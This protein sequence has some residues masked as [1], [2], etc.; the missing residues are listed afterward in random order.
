MTSF[1][2][3]FSFIFTLQIRNA[4]A[5]VS[6][7][8]VSRD[9]CANETDIIDHILYDTTVHYNRHKTPTDIVTVRIE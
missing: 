7:L 6:A 1:S 9:Y 2:L 5:A 8:D 4:F 3:I